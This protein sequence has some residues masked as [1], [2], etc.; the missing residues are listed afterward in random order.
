[1]VF[2][3]RKRISWFD[4]RRCRHFSRFAKRSKA[5]LLH[6]GIPGFESLTGYHME[7]LNVNDM[8]LPQGRLMGDATLDPDTG[9]WRALMVLNTGELAVVELNITILDNWYDRQV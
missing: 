6:G 4:S 5:P 9:K 2:V 7:T 3:P 8:E 1:M